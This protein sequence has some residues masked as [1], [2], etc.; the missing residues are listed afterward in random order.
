M[1]AL[2]L[3]GKREEVDGMVGHGPARFAFYLMQTIATK[4]WLILA[5]NLD[6][7]MIFFAR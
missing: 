4:A 2:A 3:L 1:S 6:S 7:F 5:C